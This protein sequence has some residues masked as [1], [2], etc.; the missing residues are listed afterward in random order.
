MACAPVTGLHDRLDVFRA[1]TPATDVDAHGNHRPNHL[2]TERGRV[3]IEHEP[4]AITHPSGVHYPTY[5]GATLCFAA[6][7]GEVVLADE[8]GGGQSHVGHNEPLGMMPCGPGQKGVGGGPIQDPIY[9]S[10][11]G[12]GEPGV[13]IDGHL[14]DAE[15]G[16][17]GRQL[18]IQ[19]LDQMVLVDLLRSEA[20]NLARG[21][22]ALVG[23]TGDERLD[24]TGVPEESRFQGPLDGADVRLGGVSVEARSVV[25]KVQPVRRH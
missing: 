12:G 22:D 24:G 23:A 7:R 3:D 20:D 2:M 10:S 4:V 6:E 21:V 1:K 8:S 14:S 17:L 16:N 13:E 25:S 11:S 9:V 5:C 18:P 15:N 19:R